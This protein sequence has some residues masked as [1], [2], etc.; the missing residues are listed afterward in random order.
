V[1]TEDND[2]PKRNDVRE[3]T[4]KRRIKRERESLMF[5]ILI[6]GFSGGL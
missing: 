5:P 3:I 1:V 2:A 4:P 6:L